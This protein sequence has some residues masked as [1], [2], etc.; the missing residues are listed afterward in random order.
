MSKTVIILGANGRFGRAARQAFHQAGW[1]VRTFTRSAPDASAP[2][3]F[4]AHRGDAFNA[5]ALIKAAQGCDVIVNALNPPY[6]NWKRDLPRLTAAVIEAAKATGATVMLPGNVYNYGAGM[7][8]D[9]TEHTPHTPT[10]R[11]GR[12]REAMEETYAIAADD[13]VQTII[14]RGGDFIE[15]AKT[16][17]WFDTYITAKA[18][19]GK[20]TY[21]G[22]LDRVHA[23][24]YLPDMARAMVGL[25]EKRTTLGPFTSIGF[26]G[27]NLTG[28]ELIEK[29][30]QAYGRPMKVS[31]MP[32][33]IM[34]VLGTVMPSIREVMEMRYL[35]QVPHALDD[36]YLRELLPDYRSTP[37]EQALI[38]ALGIETKPA[39]PQSVLATV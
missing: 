25:A 29:I 23:W 22:P 24:A 28:A 16:G 12:L 31:R 11:K 39:Q 10:T 18:A 26:G 6:Q 35:W 9:L 36:A 17:N 3:S 4:E 38:E 15:Q 5:G 27:F 21:P 30:E 37:I 1:A 13:G 7:P 32:W 34:R 2:S 8:A 19:Q 33:S 20:L 14:L